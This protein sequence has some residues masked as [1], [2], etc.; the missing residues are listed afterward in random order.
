MLE[1]ERRRRFDDSQSCDSRRW[2]GNT[3]IPSDQRTAQGNVAYFLYNCKR[4]HV[5]EACCADGF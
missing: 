5:S 2:F 4:G 3:F 1:K